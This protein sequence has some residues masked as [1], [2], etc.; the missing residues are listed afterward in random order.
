MSFNLPAITV[1]SWGT[2]MIDMFP[3]RTKASDLR[4][5]NTI[6]PCCSSLSKRSR[7]AISLNLL[8]TLAGTGYSIQIILAY[9]VPLPYKIIL[10]VCMFYLS[11]DRLVVSQSIM[12]LPYNIIGCCQSFCFRI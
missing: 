11:L 6:C 2:S 4:R 9:R 8:S 3:P 5:G 10:C 1:V 12:V 7:Q